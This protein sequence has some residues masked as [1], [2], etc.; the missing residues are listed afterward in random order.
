VKAA[1]KPGKIYPFSVKKNAARSRACGQHMKFKDQP[2][3]SGCCQP[4]IFRIPQP[5]ARRRGM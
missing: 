4:V 1:V 5:L 2:K 3:E